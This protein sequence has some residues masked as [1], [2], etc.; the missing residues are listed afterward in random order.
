MRNDNWAEALDAI[1]TE[2][3]SEPFC[4]GKNDCALFAADCVLAMT[5]QDYAA[6]FR[7]KY[8]SEIGAVKALKRYGKGDLESTMDAQFP[9]KPVTL[10]QRGDVVMR[11]GALGICMG[12]TSFFVTIADG[13]AGYKTADCL[14]AWGV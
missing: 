9:R 8:D 3:M 7:G 5:G 6:A 12:A 11:E 4:W 13:L 1:L 2:R 10:A 14:T